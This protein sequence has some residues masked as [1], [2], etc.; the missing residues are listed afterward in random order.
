MWGLEHAGFSGDSMARKVLDRGQDFGS[1]NPTE[2]GN[3]RFQGEEQ[4]PPFLVAPA[5]SSS[6]CCCSSFSSCLC[7]CCFC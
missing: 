6:C 4:P 2:E 1:V 5:S 3:L 7:C